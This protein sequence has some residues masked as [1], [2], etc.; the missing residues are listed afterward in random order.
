MI[1]RSILKLTYKN[2]QNFLSLIL[3]NFEFFY[4][5]FRTFYEIWKFEDFNED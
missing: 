2:L 4:D 1:F 5:N 3:W